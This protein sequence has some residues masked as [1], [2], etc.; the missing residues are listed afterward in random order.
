ML[1][2][3]SRRLNYRVRIMRFSRQRIDTQIEIQQAEN[4][5]AD[6]DSVGREQTHRQRFSRKRIDTKIEIQQEENRHIDRDSVGRNR[7]TD[8]VEIQQV[9]IDSQKLQRLNRYCTNRHTNTVEIRQVEIDLQILQRFSRQKY[10]D[11]D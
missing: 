6:R 9:E 10:T 1:L 11:R 8:T 2:R 5:D 4:R 3:R 7:H